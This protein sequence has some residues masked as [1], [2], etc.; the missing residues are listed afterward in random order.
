MAR[1]TGPIAKANAAGAR[2]NLKPPT[3]PPSETPVFD[4]ERLAGQ[5]YSAE[6]GMGFVQGKNFFNSVG[7]F[8]REAPEAQWYFPTAVQEEN[9]RKDRARHRQ[10]FGK[11]AGAAQNTPAL[12]AKLLQAARENGIAAAAEAWAE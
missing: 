2:L 3:L 9:N 8:V 12:P 7:H 11:K 10:I 1:G 6:G 5:T 4:P